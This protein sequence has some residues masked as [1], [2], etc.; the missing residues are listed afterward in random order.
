MKRMTQKS[1]DEKAIKELIGSGDTII[2]DDVRNIVVQQ[3]NECRKA[4]GS[5]S[6]SSIDK[7]NLFLEK[8]AGNLKQHTSKII[9]ANEKDIE[10]AKAQSMKESFIDRLM[11][12]K[13]RIDSLCVSLNELAALSD[14]L[15]MDGICWK[16]PSGIQIEKIRVPFGVIGIVYEGRPNVTIDTAS[17]CIK[18]GNCAVLKGSQTTIH[19]NRVL[20]QLIQQSLEES[21][22]PS[23]AVQLLSGR[24][25]AAVM[26]SLRSKI[27]V[28]IPRGSASFIDF[29]RKTSSIPVI[30]TGAGNC[31]LYI[32]ESAPVEMAILIAVNA[33][34]SRPSVCNAVETILVNSAWAKVH[35]DN[36]LC[37]LEGYGVEV[38]GCERSRQFI[39]RIP[40][41][42]EEDYKAEFNDLIIAVKIVDTIEEAVIH[43]NEYSTH[44]SEGIISLEDKEVDTFFKNV[45]SAVLYHNCSTRFTDGY[46][47]GFG[48]EIGISNQKLHARG[49]MGLQEMTTYKYLI[50]GNGNIR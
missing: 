49:P 20:I 39:P 27:D 4:I 23:T 28:V 38:R 21:G 40:P 36:L 37:R 35:F 47:F 30:E 13:L 31:H 42:S 34:V 41:A 33:K 48:A 15:A 9:T 7:R 6:T 26:L 22:F 32:A 8:L 50:R 24:E 43:I 10:Q 46:E 2:D 3:V 17:I 11:L 14:P 1:N 5:V 25:E 29:V 44:H 45:D 19:T 16:Q 18:T 12:G